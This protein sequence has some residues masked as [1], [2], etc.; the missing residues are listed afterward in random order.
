MGHYEALSVCSGKFHIHS[1]EENVSANKIEQHKTSHVSL[2]LLSLLKK[3]PDC[4][5]FIS[6]SF[7][8]IEWNP[9]CTYHLNSLHDIT[10]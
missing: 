6:P 10:L 9:V 3:L 4:H 2:I 5:Q 1:T 8:F 7:H